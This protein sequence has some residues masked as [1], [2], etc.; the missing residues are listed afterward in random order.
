MADS[1]PALPRVFAYPVRYTPR[2]TDAALAATTLLLPHGFLI[3]GSP[4]G[5]Q[6][7]I[8]ERLAMLQRPP[9]DTADLFFGFLPLYGPPMSTWTED[10]HRLMHSMGPEREDYIPISLR[11]RVHRMCEQLGNSTLMRTQLPHLT[12][13]TLKRHVLVTPFVPHACDHEARLT[14]RPFPPRREWLSHIILE[15]NVDN[16]VSRDDI[17]HRR[18][19]MPYLSSVRW[20]RAWQ[21]VPPWQRAPP[22]ERNA[23]QSRS[24]LVSFTGSLRGQPISMQLRTRLVASCRARAAHVCAAHVS[25]NFPILAPEESSDAE[26][27]SMRRALRL[28]LH[29][30]FCLEPPG[31]SPP[32]KSSLD[33]M[34]SGCIPVFFYSDEEFASL[35]PFHMGGLHGWGANASVRVPLEAALDGSVDVIEYLQA[36]PEAR[37]RAMQSMLAAHAHTLL[38]GIGPYSGDAIETMLAALHAGLSRPARARH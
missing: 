24:H 1:K 36:V 9:A 22:T 8:A 35:W 10:D 32:R 33:S 17:R 28:K 6:T 15:L 38:Y 29:S 23:A 26:R 31:F 20:S 11:V 30:T 27:M 2:S 37:I 21:G 12:R 34:L 4:S 19:S 14:G 5:L 7:T 25:D 16:L 13:R 3:D 18:I